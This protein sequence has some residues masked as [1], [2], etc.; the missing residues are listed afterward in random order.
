MA[1]Q[2]RDTARAAG[3]QVPERDVLTGMIRRWERGYGVSERY[4]LHY[5]QVFGIEADEYGTAEPAPPAS[6]EPVTPGMLLP[7]PATP[8]SGPIVAPSAA[9]AYRGIQEPG[10]CGSWI[11][12][13]VLMAA[14]DN[15]E[16]AEQAERRDI[17]DA[18]L[19]QLRADVIR[20]SAESMTGEPF[21]VFQDMRR[22]SDRIHTVLDRRIWPRDQVELYFL[23][24]CL[25]GLM[26]IEAWHLGSPAA[27]Q[28]LLRAGWAYATVIDNRPLLGHIRLMR[29][30]IAYW[31]G[32]PQECLDLASN[33]LNYVSSGPNGALLHLIRARA[34]ASM[35]DADGARGAVAAAHHVRDL[36]SD[37]DLLEIGGEFSFSRASEHYFAGSA[38][39]SLPQG[40]AEA[41]GEL[42]QAV[43]MYDS[44][45]EPNEQHSAYCILAARADLATADLRVG[46]LDAAIAAVGP[47]LGLSAARRVSSLTVCLGRT[48]RELAHP[49]YQ[50][51]VQARELGERI[52]EFCRQTVVADLHSL[53]GG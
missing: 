5:C 33:G 53:P 1:R 20:L 34:A 8:L 38:L 27:A 30:D 14:H 4:R 37:E 40:G 47:V 3:D 36:D 46:R 32:R 41:I 19:E 35:G 50:G 9:V 28:E 6:A 25:N 12:R 11:A 23:L 26:S 24:A 7:V 29:A 49:I 51:S 13:E 52:E 43:Q 17:G 48:R 22:V 21:A 39:I 42:E 31:S 16:H 18:T 45:P 2:L 10:Q 44:T 15:S